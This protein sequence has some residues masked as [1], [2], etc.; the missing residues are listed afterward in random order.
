MNLSCAEPVSYTHL[1]CDHPHVSGAGRFPRGDAGPHSGPDG[2]GRHRLHLSLIHIFT[3]ITYYSGFRAGFCF[4]AGATDLVFSASLPAAAKTWKIIPL[5][6]AAF[7]VFYAVFYL[8][9]IHISRLMIALDA[10]V[11]SMISV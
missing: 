6:I 3:I 5:G 2:S 8:S 9:L 4:S 11:L 7:L 10:P 1:H